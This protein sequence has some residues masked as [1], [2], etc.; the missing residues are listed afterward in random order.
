[1]KDADI[2]PF[3]GQKWQELKTK[4]NRNNLFEDP[5]F[6]ATAKSLYYSNQGPKGAVWRRAGVNMIQ[7]LLKCR[8]FK[9]SAYIGSH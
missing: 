9:I 2:K 6:P 4:Y 3:K 5:L 1:M 8:L 7:L